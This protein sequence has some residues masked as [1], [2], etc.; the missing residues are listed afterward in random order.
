MRYFVA[1]QRYLESIHDYEHLVGSRKSAAVQAEMDLDIETSSDGLPLDK[2]R[3]RTG[4]FNDE[5][6]NF[7]EDGVELSDVTQSYRE[8][9]RS[10]EDFKEQKQM[11]D[12][13]NVN[14]DDN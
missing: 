2:T 6:L 9:I 4:T 13:L 3:S 8:M 14:N 5:M 12:S 11:L 10:L 7:F 1:K